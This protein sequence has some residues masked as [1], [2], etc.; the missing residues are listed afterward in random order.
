MQVNKTVRDIF[1]Q[2]F[3]PFISPRQ[4]VPIPKSLW[5][6]RAEYAGVIPSDGVWAVFATHEEVR[7]WAQPQ[8]RQWNQK[9]AMYARPRRSPRTGEMIQSSIHSNSSTP[10]LPLSLLFSFHSSIVIYKY[11]SPLTFSPS[12]TFAGPLRSSLVRQR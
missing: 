5:T 4:L 10:F 7:N 1:V 2:S 6:R 9:K 3:F 12:S 11:N 8:S